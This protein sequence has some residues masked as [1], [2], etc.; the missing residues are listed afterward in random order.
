MKQC[1][2]CGEFK[3]L[4]EFYKQ[5]GLKDGL[6][7]YCKIC[8][9]IRRRESQEREFNK[10]HRTI[11][12]NDEKLCSCC[13]GWKPLSAF[14]TRKT[15]FDGL[16][17]TCKLCAVKQNRIAQN[18]IK[19]NSDNIELPI[20]LRQCA[21]CKKLKD[22]GCFSRDRYSPDGLEHRCKECMAKKAHKWYANNS[23]EIAERKRERLGIKKMP[24]I[25]R[26]IDGVLY[27][28]CFKCKEW[29]PIF[30]FYRT[31]ATIDG[32]SYQCKGCASKDG[33][34]YRRGISR[35][36]K[37]P[38]ERYAIRVKRLISTR[39]SSVNS[40]SRQMGI[41]GYITVEEWESLCRHFEF[42]CINP[43]C[44]KQLP[45]ESITI[46]HVISRRN[47]GSNWISNIQPL[48]LDCNRKK[49]RN[50]TDYRSLAETTLSDSQKST[51]P[52]LDF[53]E[54]STW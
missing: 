40:H 25:R 22:V 1:K 12:G 4:S 52:G 6:S 24:V 17:G 9:E 15:S 48:C 46:D 50:N 44:W 10:F 23:V 32:Y 11:N 21:K 20:G 41:E 37:S 19:E 14:G 29:K 7:N 49:N 39:V 45:F 42:R 54:H 53:E 27:K 26:Y 34:L 30:L 31:A 35:R 36:E 28:R 51:N 43:D 3:E 13:K 38:E 16:N 5:A 47:R 18:K 8:F 33:M 2:C